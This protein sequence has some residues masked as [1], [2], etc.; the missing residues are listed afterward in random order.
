MIRSNPP[1]PFCLRVVAVVLAAGFSSRMGAAKALLSWKGEPFLASI[2]KQYRSCGISAVVVLGEEA[3]QIAEKV[4]LGGARVLV[5]PRPQEGPISSLRC[6][7]QEI[8]DSRGL[9]LHPVDHPA[10][11]AQTLRTLTAAHLRR[12]DLILLPSYR[13]R[14][15]HPVLF[16][17]KFYPELRRAPL[18]AGARWVVHG[19]RAHTQRIPVADPGILRNINTREDYAELRRLL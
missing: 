6:A 15:G 16:P 3:S 8:G 14:H 10:V 7:L 19:Q 1:L 13:G 2:L 5:N 18:E 11:T 9:L 4:N 12:P 17:A